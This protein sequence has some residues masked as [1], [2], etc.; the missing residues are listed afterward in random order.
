MT[1]AIALAGV[2]SIIFW[3]AVAVVSVYITIVRVRG[4]TNLRGLLP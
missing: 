4:I 3:G 2:S 1:L